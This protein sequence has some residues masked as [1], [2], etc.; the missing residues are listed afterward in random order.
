MVSQRWSGDTRRLGIAS[1]IA[2]T[3]I[4]TCY[5]AV[6]ASWLF[7]EAT[8]REPIGDPYLAAME[9]LTMLSALA[10]IGLLIAIR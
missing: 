6:I 8:P 7:V 9:I 10:L 3:A 5:V 1:A 2:I 4:G